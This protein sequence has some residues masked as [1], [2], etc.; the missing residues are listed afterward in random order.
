M[1]SGIGLGD[2]SACAQ[3]L[4]QPLPWGL[5]GILC[6]LM[7]VFEDQLAH[8]GV[9]WGVAETATELIQSGRT[10]PFVVV[11]V[12]SAGPMRSLNYLPYPP[13]TG[14]LPWCW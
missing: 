11:A 14:E 4:T 12:D 2:Q 10:P 8:Q 5:P 3:P 1:C 9:S 6:P 7:T 13:G